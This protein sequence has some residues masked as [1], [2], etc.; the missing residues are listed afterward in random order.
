MSEEKV[1]RLEMVLLGLFMG[2][3]MA[4]LASVWIIM[5]IYGRGV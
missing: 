3:S 2:V 5:I 4:L 1:T